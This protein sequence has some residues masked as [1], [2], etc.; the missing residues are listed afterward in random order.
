[1]TG[2]GISVLLSDF[3]VAVARKRG[4]QGRGEENGERRTEH[5]KSFQGRITVN[6]HNP[7]ISSPKR[8]LY[9][10]EVVYIIMIIFILLSPLLRLR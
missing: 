5:G 6:Y 1:M 3:G 10:V 2:S 9:E 4:E 7:K 8:G